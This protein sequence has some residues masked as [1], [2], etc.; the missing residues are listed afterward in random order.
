MNEE[1][2]N[3]TFIHYDADGMPAGVATFDELY[4]QTRKLAAMVVQHAGKD[5]DFITE[6]IENELRGTPDSIKVAQLTNAISFIS[7]ALG[8]ELNEYE[9]A[10]G[11]QEMRRTYAKAIMRGADDAAAEI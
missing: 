1:L 10:S 4:K 7:M 3:N 2:D 6:L 9:E 8:M 11:T 5:S